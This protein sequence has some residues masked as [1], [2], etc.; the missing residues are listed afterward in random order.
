MIVKK[1]LLIPKILTTELQNI[2]IRIKILYYFLI[3]NYRNIAILYKTSA[4]V[5]CYDIP[6]LAYSYYKIS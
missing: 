2:D 4:M 5:Y 6:H 3:D 1:D